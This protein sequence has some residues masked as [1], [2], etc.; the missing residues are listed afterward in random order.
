[1]PSGYPSKWRRGVTYLLS[2][3]RGT[4]GMRNG[5]GGKRLSKRYGILN[6]PTLVT[7]VSRGAAITFNRLRLDCAGRTFDNIPAEDAYSFHVNF[8]KQESFS[9]SRKARIA[10]RY[11][12][13]EGDST[14]LDYSET[15]TVI[16]HT[17][18]DTVRLYVPRPTLQDFVREEYGSREAHLKL[19][20]QVMR[21][22]ILYRLGSC[23]SAL[24][25][26]PEENNSLL[27]DHI[28]LSLQC[29]LYQTYSATPTWNPKAR[30]GLA[31]WQE[32]RAKEAM[33]ANLDKE[34]T[35]ARLACDCGLSTSQFARA[36]RQ[37]TGCPP[38]RWLLQRRIKRAQD[39][40]LTSNKTLAEIARAC[41]FSDQSH[42]TRAFGQ[43]VGTSPGLWR[44]IKRI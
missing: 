3:P 39:L 26:H 18:M 22:P 25:E 38:H 43:T 21:D 1:M 5:Y 14:M 13:G 30:G 17:A 6:V 31:P 15:S 12:L 44:R 34:I 41:G 32:S 27:V 23:L 9:A 24:L 16:L 33:D 37:S 35:I 7:S 4:T 19:P 10:E 36:F 20:Q 28:A 8:L 2:K 42:L 11:F 29:H 40:L